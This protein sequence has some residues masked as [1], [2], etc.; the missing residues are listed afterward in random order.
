[1]K[2]KNERKEAEKETFSW[3]TIKIT[4]DR[5]AIVREGRSIVI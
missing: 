1:M 2:K 4:E 3:V 5:F